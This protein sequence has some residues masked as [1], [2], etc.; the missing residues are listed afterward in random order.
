MDIQHLNRLPI[1][2]LA[3]LA[4]QMQI[5]ETHGLSRQELILQILTE[6]AY[7]NEDIIGE[8]TLE[9]VDGGFGFLRGSENSYLPA[10]SDIYVSPS[11]VKRFRLQTGDTIRGIVRQ[12]KENERYLALIRVSEIN[13]E[14]VESARRRFRFDDLTPVYPSQRL[15]LD[16]AKST[17]SARLIDLFAPIGFGQRALITTPP[18]AGGT[19]LLIDLA[20]TLNQSHPETHICLLL[21]DAR[22]EEVIALQ[23]T[24]QIEV[25]GSCFDEFASRHVQVSEMVLEK[26]KRLVECGQDVILLIDSLSNLTRSYSF[27]TMFKEASK[28]SGKESGKE[29]H[30]EFQVGFNAFMQI[31]RFFGAARNLEE[32]GSLTMIA[33]C[34]QTE[35]AQD[36]LIYSELSKA[37]NSQIS[38]VKSTDPSLDFPVIDLLNSQ[39]RYDDELQD[40]EDLQTL[41]ALLKTGYGV[42]PQVYFEK[43]C[44]LVK[45]ST[46]NLEFL[47]T[48]DVQSVE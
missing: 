2:D 38:L 45:P 9:I 40:E 4:D 19:R 12:P 29:T 1:P 37:C 33:T 6:C 27:A 21:I 11:Q 42:D 39:T 25:V 20:K 46:D 36:S 31:K 44:K 34:T 24:L 7:Q 5:E 48:I 16:G 23:R 41:T 8:G 22:P 13:G 28:E 26:A 18:Q 32:G 15:H 35:N 47:E 43:I 10:S 30:K 14:D 17:T 3:S